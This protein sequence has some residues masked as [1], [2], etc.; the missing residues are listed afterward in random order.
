MKSNVRFLNSLPVFW[1][2]LSLPAIILIRRYLTDD[3]IAMDMLNPTGEWS[4]RFMIIAMMISPLTTIFGQRGW[5]NWLLRRRRAFGL[6]AFGYAVL[7]LIYYVLDMELWS[8]MLAE[9]GAP[10]IWTGWLAFLI[11]LPMAITSNNAA[12]RLLRAR[13]KM[14]QRIVYLAALLTLAHWL[15]IHDGMV[16]ALVHFIPLALLQLLRGIIIYARRQ[17]QSVQLEQKL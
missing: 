11:F 9:I 10:S 2:L 6:A 1:I 12:M 17:S 4:A 15:L 8:A 5:T 14:L 13:W 3:V 7:H 16:D